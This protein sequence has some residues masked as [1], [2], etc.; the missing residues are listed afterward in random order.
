MRSVSLLILTL[1][2]SARA[3][4]AQQGDISA[5]LWLTR[6]EAITS[7]LVKD[8]SDL[9]P[10]DRALLLARLAERW[11]RDDPARAHAWMLKPIE[12]VENVPNRENPTERSER[13]STARLLLQ[14]VAPL[15]QKLS[16]RLITLLTA[17][18]DHM[19][20]AERG[21]NADG[22][23][24]AAILLVDIDPQRAAELGTL[25]LRVGPPTQI[26]G[27]IFKLR[28]KDANLSNSLFL[29]TIAIARQ[30]FDPGLLNSLSHAT[31]PESRTVG[32]TSR[33]L[34]PDQ[35]RA[36]VL[37]VYIAYLQANPINAENRNSVCTKVISYIAP[38]LAQFDALL[39]QQEFN[40]RQSINQCQSESPL[41][42]Q[43]LDDARREQ[44]L[45]T[46][47]DLLK[48]GAD[49][50]DAKVSTVYQ[51]RAATL[52][53]NENDLERAIKILDNMNSEA[54]EFMGSSWQAYRWDWAALAA[55]Q[56]FKSGDFNGM[57]TLINDVPADLRSFAKIALVRELPVSRNEE[58]DPTLEFVTDARTGLR[59]SANSE[60]K[61]SWYFGLLPLIVKYQPAEATSVL[62]EA[63]ATLNH[64]DEAK[65]KSDGNASRRQLIG[66][67]SKNLP[68]TLLEMDEY[69]V[70]EAISGI[71]AADARAQVR[72]ELLTACL[73]RLRSAKKAT[74][75]PARSVPVGG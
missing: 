29:Q 64:F 8:S 13:L 49:A 31:F 18:S 69:T 54:R 21:A 1:A 6:S 46:V 20:D 38:V 12:T 7:E 68:A 32:L 3:G 17:D 16:K 43:R 51:F 67:V 40:V 65:D 57:R 41:V 61:C 11:W 72:L 55:L 73:E 25:A 52:A 27:L 71:T 15:D 28:N 30:T 36:E 45:N 24:K 44:P 19:A 2:I 9:T 63:F 70:K 37:R 34:W 26:Q 33:T 48:A 14:I 50:K 53:K 60:E 35:V 4:F 56:R 22:L 59:R 42:R 75:N 62:K 74:P 5:D 66:S 23:I 58:T 39:P 10:S 47:D